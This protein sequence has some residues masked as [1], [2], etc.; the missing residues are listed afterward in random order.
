MPDYDI[1]R[2]P[3][4]VQEALLQLT[5]RLVQ[6]WAGAPVDALPIPSTARCTHGTPTTPCC[7]ACAVLG[8]A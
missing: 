5:E 4:P 3:S 8:A 6:A 2:L 7:P 1:S